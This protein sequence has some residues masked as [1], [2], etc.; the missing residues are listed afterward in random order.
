MSPERAGWPR[1]G[2]SWSGSIV[3]SS[4]V[5][6]EPLRVDVVAGPD[7]PLDDRDAVCWEIQEHEHLARHGHDVRDEIFEANDERPDVVRCEPGSPGSVVP[8]HLVCERLDLLAVV[9]G[10][11]GGV[12]WVVPV[13]PL[14]GLDRLCP[15]D[16]L[17]GNVFAPDP[18][19]VWTWKVSF[20]ERAVGHGVA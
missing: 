2:E 9:D 6:A 10:D 13:V 17:G 3:S 1:H 20:D 5:P 15:R 8:G 14:A 19:E 4:Q 7:C 11:G 16:G 18:D 12:G